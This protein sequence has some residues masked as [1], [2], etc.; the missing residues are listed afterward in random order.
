MVQIF[1][2]GHYNPIMFARF[3]IQ[4]QILGRR[5]AA[6]WAHG[7]STVAATL[8]IAMGLAACGQ[9][10]PLFLPPPPKARPAGIAP[11]AAPAAA[12][13]APESATATPTDLPAPPPA[14][15][16]ATLPPR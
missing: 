3:Q 8:A 9:K 1:Q 2:V 13:S 12:A 4:R 14:S 6:S 16:P 15:G 5:Q 11:V 10:G 7:L